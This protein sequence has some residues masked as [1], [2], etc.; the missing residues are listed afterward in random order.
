[1]TPA[2]RLPECAWVGEARTAT[3][4]PRPRTCTYDRTS[5]Q[6]RMLS[7]IAHHDLQPFTLQ[8]SFQAWG[9]HAVHF[10]SAGQ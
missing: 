10:A 4:S 5:A 9:N 2:F 8:A 3:A 6:E 7:K 1:M